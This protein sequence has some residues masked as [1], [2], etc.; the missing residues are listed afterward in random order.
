MTRK[1]TVN[2]NIG[3][4]FD[5][6]REMIK[7]PSLATKLPAHC[8]IEFVEKDFPVK[9]DSVLRDKYIVKVIPHMRDEPI[10]KVAEPQAKYGRKKK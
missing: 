10:N 3:L 6:V 4:T 1:E 8:E 7:N 5:F 2:R 9:S